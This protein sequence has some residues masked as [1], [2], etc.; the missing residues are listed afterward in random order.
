MASD[1]SWV[2]TETDGDITTVSSDGSW[3]VKD[4]GDVTAV[5][6]DGSYTVQEDG[7]SS[8]KKPSLPDLPNKPSD[9]KAVTPKSPVQPTTA[10]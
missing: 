5:D 4:G 1:G 10:G 9:S 3:T 6:A 8:T 2:R 7:K